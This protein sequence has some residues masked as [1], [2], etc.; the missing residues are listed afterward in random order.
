MIGFQLISVALLC[1]TCLVNGF[2]GIF[3]EVC[4]IELSQKT[5]RAC[6]ER[7]YRQLLVNKKVYQ[8]APISFLPDEPIRWLNMTYDQ[9]T[10]VFGKHPFEQWEFNIYLA[11]TAGGAKILEQWHKLNAGEDIQSFADFVEIYTFFRK[12]Q[13][14]LGDPYFKNPSDEEPFQNIIKY[15]MRDKVFAEQRLAGVNPMTLKRISTDKDVGLKW[16]ELKKVL[17]QKFDW[18]NLIINTP[19]LPKISLAKAISR[20]MVFVL[21]YPLLDYLPAMPDIMESRPH[22]KMWDPTSPIAFFAVHPNNRNNLIPIAIQMDVKPGSPVYTPKDGDLWMLAKL[23]VQGAD[24][25]YNQVAEHLAKTHLLLEPFCVSKDRQLSENH[26]LHQVI[27]YHCRGI[28]ITDKL[29]FQFLL[30]ENQNLHRLFPYGYLGAVNIALKSYRQTSWKDTDFIGNIRERGLDF[31][32]L[33]YFPYRDDGYS[34][35]VTIQKAVRDY[36]KQYYECDEEVQNDYEL[37]NF[38]NEVSADGVGID[39]GNG[40]VKDLPYELTSVDSLVVFLTRLLWQLSGQH[41]ALNYPVADYGGFTL[42]MPTKL[43]RDRR[44]S[45]D[46]FSLFSFPNA[47]ISARHAIVA[48]SLTN[49]RYDSLF[50]YGSQLPDKRGRDVMS[51]WF[52]F[53]QRLVQPKLEKRNQNRLK[54]DH[55][56]Y[57]YLLPRWIPNG[58]QT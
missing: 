12:A 44:V 43:Y 29:A 5:S 3:G 7:R 50:D 6:Q 16:S 22:R 17:N 47:N 32:T 28:S 25:G 37:Q 34:I 2:A 26:P 55:L 31:R 38:M 54:G 8:L 14:A 53:L 4:P 52:Y 21:R 58:I 35:F 39:G 49:Y 10:A 19:N 24:L 18:D 23:S 13:E 48:F 40:N 27:K 46:V 57:P 56:T 45:N 11:K 20:K 41:A 36:V 51:K 15:W 33:R 42:N 30:G 1:M 9:M